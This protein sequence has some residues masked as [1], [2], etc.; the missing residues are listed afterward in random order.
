MSQSETKTERNRWLLR[1]HLGTH[2]C[3]DK[4]MKL[5]FPSNSLRHVIRLQEIKEEDTRDAKYRNKQEVSLSSC[6]SK[7]EKEEGNG[8]DILRQVK[9]IFKRKLKIL[10]KKNRQNQSRIVKIRR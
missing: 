5:K 6:A 3:P 8:D 4:G 1:Q 10:K 7:S 9:Q 2:G